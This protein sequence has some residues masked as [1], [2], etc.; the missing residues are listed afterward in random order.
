MLQHKDTHKIS[1]LKNGF[2]HRW[3]EADFILSSLTCF[4]LSMANK[5]FAGLKEKGYSLASLFGIL[6]SLPFIGQNSVN[7]LLHSNLGSYIEARKDTFYRFKNLEAINWR[8]ILWFFARQFIKLSKKE[9]GGKSPRCLIFDDSVLQKSGKFIERISRV[10]DHVTGR[11]VLGYKLLVAVYWDGSSCIPVDYSIHRE[12]GKKKDMPFGLKKKVMKNQFRKA[13]NHSSSAYERIKETDVSKIA[14]MVAMLKRALRNKLEVDYVLMDSWF[15]CWEVVSLIIKRKGLHL[16]G[17]YK[18]AKTKFDYMGKSLTY[19]QV[20]ERIKETDVSKIA[21][22]VA[23]LK[24][25][26]RNKLEVDYVLMDSWFTCWEVVSLIIKRKGLHLIGM[27]KGAKTKFDYMGKSLTYSQ[28]RNE[29]GNPI[30]CRR[31]GYY[32]K[33]AIVQWNGKQVR[34][35]FSKQGKNGKWKTFMSTNTSLSF[36]EMVKI[37]QLRWC[38]EVFFKESKQLFGLGKCQSTDFDAQIADTTMVMIRYMMASL[39]YRFDN[40]ESKG[41]IFEQTKEKAVMY[42]LGERLWG[43]FLELVKII[44]VLFDGCDSDDIIHRL[45]ENEQ[46]AE[47]IGRLLVVEPPETRK[48]A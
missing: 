8:G 32:Y 45:L 17:M 40:Y 36:I 22:M 28:V 43:L 41:A 39:K 15:T 48:A 9:N 14:S 11:C 21:S 20:N 46:A 23:M 34:L 24:R 25:A 31:L 30:R 3:F 18:G 2:T 38:I 47:T 29:L 37:Y 4:K 7:G 5:C 44:E 12:K 26:L 10:W 13:R 35:F 16:I 1:E 27:Y 19:S 6:L 42:S 33:Q